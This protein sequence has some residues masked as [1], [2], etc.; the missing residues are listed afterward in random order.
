MHAAPDWS[1]MRERNWVR[2][3]GEGLADDREEAM[4]GSLV[5]D[6]S[7]RRAPCVTD[8]AFWIAASQPPWGLRE[9]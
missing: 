1:T 7:A 2:V 9:K 6:G 3:S 5:A 8:L 4:L